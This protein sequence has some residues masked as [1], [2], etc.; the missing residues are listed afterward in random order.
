MCF[1]MIYNM[2]IFLKFETF[3]EA[4]VEPFRETCS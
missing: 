2:L 1:K 3:S 4:I